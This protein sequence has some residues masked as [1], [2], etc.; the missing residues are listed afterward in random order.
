MNDA[1]LQGFRNMAD[2]MRKAR[3]ESEPRWQWI[4]QHMSQRMFGISRERAEAYAARYGG[5]AREM[6]AA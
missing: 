5:E 4:G 3:G 2:E 6:K 1:T